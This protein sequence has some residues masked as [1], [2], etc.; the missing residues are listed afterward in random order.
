MHIDNW[1]TLDEVRVTRALQGKIMRRFR[2]FSPENIIR[3]KDFHIWSCM[4][5]VYPEDTRVCMEDVA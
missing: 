2:R 4:W 1:N 5:G 3:I